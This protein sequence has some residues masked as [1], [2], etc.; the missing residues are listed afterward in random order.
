LDK[1]TPYIYAGAGGIFDIRSPDPNLTE[2]SSGINLQYGLALKYNINPK[3]SFFISAEN[4]HTTSDT[5]DDIVNGK[6]DDFYYNFSIGM[7]F[8]IGKKL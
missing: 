1:L 4:N 7:E 5:I 3:V 2:D 6:R 8:R